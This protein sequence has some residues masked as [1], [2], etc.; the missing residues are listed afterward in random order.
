V[1]Y[2]PPLQLPVLSAPGDGSP[3]KIISR[4][5]RGQPNGWPGVTRLCAWC[6][7][8]IPARA[9]R[10]AV[11]CSVRC[12]QARH[13][14]LRAVGYAESVAPTR[15]GCPVTA[16]TVQGMAPYPGQARWLA[17]GFWPECFRR[18]NVK[19]GRR[20]FPE[21]TRSAL[22]IEGKHVTIQG[23]SPDLSHSWAFAPSSFG[24]HLIRRS[25]RLST[26]G[27]CICCICACARLAPGRGGSWAAGL[28]R[29]ARIGSSGDRG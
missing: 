18:L 6:E 9:R 21:E 1:V 11:C 7:K 14:F 28:V 2:D 20:T 26:M 15:S 17:L 16:R 12:R 22:D 25:G 24:E 23:P 5:S 10:D 4:I 3:G 27:P 29:G 19:G 8:P 13:R